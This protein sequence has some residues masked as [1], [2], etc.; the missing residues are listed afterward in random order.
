MKKNFITIGIALTVST[1][2]SMTAFAGN[3][4][5]VGNDWKYKED[6]GTYTVNGWQW[7]DGKSYYFDANGIMAKDTIVDGYTVN[8]DGQWTVNGV[9]QTQGTTGQPAN[10]NG[11]NH[12]DGYDPAHPLKN[13]MDDWNLRQTPETN[14]LNYY[15]ICGNE[16]VQALLTGQMEYYHERTGNLAYLNETEQALYQWFCNWLNGMDFEHMTEMERAKEIQKVLL[17]GNNY[18]IGDNRNGYYA[19]LIDKVSYCAESAMTAMTLAKALGLRAAVYGS[20]THAEYYIQVDGVPYMGS[21]GGLHLD[22]QI[23]YTPYWTN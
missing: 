21:N 7:I 12:S 1:M 17:E 15:Y 6:N 3:W 9:V 11:V 23:S 13:V 5:T 22:R 14:G 8:A 18:D 20:G 10:T 4:E 16:N 19:V 2:M